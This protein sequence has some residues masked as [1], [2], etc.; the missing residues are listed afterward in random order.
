LPIGRPPWEEPDQF[1]FFG[2][3]LRTVLVLLGI[4]A[5]IAAFFGGIYGLVRFIKWAWTG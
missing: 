1:G 2:L 5:A 3:V 4:I